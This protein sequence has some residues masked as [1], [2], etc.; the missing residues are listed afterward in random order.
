MRTF[1]TATDPDSY[2]GWIPAEPRILQAQSHEEVS[3]IKV[4]RP[5]LISRLLTISL[6]YL[7][8]PAVAGTGGAAVNTASRTGRTPFKI[9]ANRPKYI[10]A[11]SS[12]SAKDERKLI[13]II[14]AHCESSGSDR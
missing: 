13:E 2:S 4:L 8:L 12:I 5:F 9:S 1:R 14:L 11:E 6:G 7:T 3:N 10:S